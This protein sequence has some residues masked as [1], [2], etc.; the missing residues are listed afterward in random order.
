MWRCSTNNIKVFMMHEMLRQLKYGGPKN[1]G[2]DDVI[3]KREHMDLC[4]G[5][6]QKLMKGAMY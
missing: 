1:E 3:G 2:W 4:I 5:K 6:C